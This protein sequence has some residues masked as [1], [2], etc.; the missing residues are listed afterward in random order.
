MASLDVGS[1]EIEKND[2]LDKKFISFVNEFVVYVKN[3]KDKFDRF[4]LNNGNDEERITFLRKE[5]K[6]IFYELDEYFKA[7]WNFVEGLD[8]KKYT[9]HKLFFRS[10]LR[11][12]LL[13]SIEINK[14]IFDKPLGQPGDHVMLNYIYDYYGDLRYL[15]FSTFQKLINNYTCNIPISYSNNLRKNFFKQQI[16][17]V[18]RKGDATRIVSFGCGAARELIEILQ[19]S[20]ELPVLFF[21]LLDSNA[22]TLDDIRKIIDAIQQKKHSHVVVQYINFNYVDVLR[23]K[24][25]IKK[26][27][28]YD[29]IYCPGIFD[30]LS[31]YFA[32]KLTEFL[33]HLLKSSGVL[34]IFNAN[35]NSIY[36]RAYYEM[37]GEWVF[38]HRDKAD[39][40]FWAENIS[41]DKKFIFEQDAHS[42][43]YSYF[44]IV[45]TQC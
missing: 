26:F 29:F 34:T 35:K 45:R 33:Y 8:K 15:G 30:Y 14:Y 9:K 23:K 42:N 32:K 31:Q 25:L 28:E 3:V 6:R 36:H 44:R 13:D 16:A 19:E 39:L 5:K 7:I 21:D 4:D 27:G 37:I 40:L 10:L 11:P 24:N 38:I 18:L 12:F 2:I 41:D 22:K 1:F 17:L 43:C 20:E